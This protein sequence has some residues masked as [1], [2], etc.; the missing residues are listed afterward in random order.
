MPTT[1]AK[2]KTIKEHAT[3]KKDVG[4]T[5]VQIALLTGRINELTGHLKA[6]KK[7][8]HS[9]RGLQLMV[10]R[11]KRLL[12]YLSRTDNNAYTE[13]VKKLELRK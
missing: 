4:S 9:A 7:D 10:E 11:R 1:E 13:L 6:H 3:G 8:R 5:P 12:A 2:A